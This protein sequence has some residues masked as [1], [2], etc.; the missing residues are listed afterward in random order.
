M[1]L[2][3]EVGNMEDLNNMDIIDFNRLNKYIKRRNAQRNG[4][5]IE[6]KD[7]N[8]EMIRRA[9]ERNKWYYAEYR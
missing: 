4:K 7:S 5:P 8:K 6:L 1:S 3:L 9:K 2:Y